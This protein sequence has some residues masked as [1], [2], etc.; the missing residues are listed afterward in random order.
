MA[1]TRF[2]AL[3]INKGKTIAQTLRDRT[4]YAQNPEKTQKGELVTGYQCNPITADEEFLLA[5]RQ[6]H[7]ITGRYQDSDVIA[8]QIR[9]SFKPGEVTPEKAN[10]LGH[11]LALRFTH[12]KHAYIV[13]TH[14]DKAHI[15]NHIVFNSTTLDCTGKFQDFKRSGIVLQKVSD[16]VC[17]EN[18]L[19]IIAKKPYSQRVKYNR[20]KNKHSERDLIRND[21][22]I[23]LSRHPKSYED[24]LTQMQQ[25]GYEVKKGKH[26]SFRKGGR[27]TCF[28]RLRSLGDGYT[29]ADIR[30]VIAGEK[31][32]RSKASRYIQIERPFNLLIDL[33][34]RMQAKGPGYHRWATAYNVKQM[35]KTR[36]YLHEHGIQSIDEL[37]EKASACSAQFSLINNDLK[38]AEKRLVEIAALKT[39]IINYVKAKDTYAMYRQSGYSKDFF[40]KHRQE[41]TLHKAAKDAFDR[42]GLKK[43]PKVKDLSAE[44][45]EVLEKKKALYSEYKTARSEMQEYQTALHNVEQFYNVTAEPSHDQH[46]SDN[47]R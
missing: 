29:E 20:Y 18:G 9:Q 3:H 22:D 23:I 35:A 1:A 30:S 46:R 37:R 39:H 26:D 4:D 24:F 25:Q 33:D 42:I 32:H 10:E 31:E 27:T 47:E 44:Y 45:S 7:H 5:K 28:I 19:S 43:L 36:L 11:A 21:I 38:D 40:E 16:L 6:Y 14:V 8:Y 13:A 15:H 12:G 34:T 41:L 17:L 2:I